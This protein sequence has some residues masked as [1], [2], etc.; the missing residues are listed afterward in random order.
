M[1]VRAALANDHQPGA[2]STNPRSYGV[3][4]IR[5]SIMN[6]FGGGGSLII[7]RPDRRSA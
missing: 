7:T 3:S 6:G 1:M 4:A 2:V 5:I